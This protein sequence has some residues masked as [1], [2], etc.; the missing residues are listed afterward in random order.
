MTN[1]FNSTPFCKEF[2]NIRIF[3]QIDN[4]DLKIYLKKIYM[5]EFVKN[6]R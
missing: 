1:L 5:R 4:T 3:T 2:A 6:G